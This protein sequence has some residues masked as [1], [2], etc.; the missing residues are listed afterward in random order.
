MSSG[1]TTALTAAQARV[2]TVT[3][4]HGDP[5]TY[6]NNPAELPGCRYEMDLCLNRLGAFKLLIRHRAC[7]MPN[8]V[9]AVQDVNSIPFVMDM[10]ADPDTATYS[11][12]SPCPDTPARIAKLNASRPSGSTPFVG[13]GT[14]DK[15]PASVLKLAAPMP[16]EIEVEDHA[17]ALTQLSIFKDQKVAQRLLEQCNCRLSSTP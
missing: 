14:L 12:S 1:G 10:V 6:D 2:V 5:V 7:R 4:I 16:Y 9:I 3:D 13:Y 17:Y 15:V 11:Y 8:G